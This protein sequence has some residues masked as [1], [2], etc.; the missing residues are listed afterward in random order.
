MAGMNWDMRYLGGGLVFLGVLILIFGGVS[1]GLVLGVI[2]GVV[3]LIASSLKKQRDIEAQEGDSKDGDS[4]D[5]DSKD[6]DAED[7]Q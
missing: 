5:G 4:K 3:L 7:E 2:G 6:G 1:A